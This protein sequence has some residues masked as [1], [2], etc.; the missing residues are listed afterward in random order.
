MNCKLTRR[1]FVTTAG[2]AI[3]APAVVP[4]SVFGANAPSNRINVALIGCGNQS[5]VDLPSMLR[6][7]D[8][9]VVAVCDVNRGS[10]GYARP[11]HFL[12]RDP[13]QKKSER[14]LCWQKTLG[15][16]QRLRRLQ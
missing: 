5:R 15:D 8:A 9:Q 3:V 2:A 7:A 12:G 6:Q 4:S 13:A 14:I 11:D 16:I 1:D 10:D